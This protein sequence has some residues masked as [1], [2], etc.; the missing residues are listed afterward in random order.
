MILLNWYENPAKS[1]PLIRFLTILTTG[2]AGSAATAAISRSSVS[3]CPPVGQLR[4]SGPTGYTNSS[5]PA[6]G[7]LH[8]AAGTGY[9]PAAASHA[10][11]RRA[12]ECGTCASHSGG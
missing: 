9:S 12:G 3:G 1:E 6:A 8:H 4:L 2:S 10:G 5:G 7:L 11:V